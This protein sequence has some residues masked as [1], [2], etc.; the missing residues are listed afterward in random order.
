MIMCIS[1]DDKK[2]ACPFR[3]VDCSGLFIQPLM[4]PI[5]AMRFVHSTVNVAYTSHAP[6]HSTVNV[7]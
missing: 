7:A 4:L 6:V 5:R 2:L 1:S 3:G